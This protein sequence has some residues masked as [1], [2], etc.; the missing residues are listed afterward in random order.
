MVR[1]VTILAYSCQL[2]DQ[3]RFL[4]PEPTPIHEDNITC[5]KWSALVAWFNDCAKHINLLKHFVHEAV[6]K[7]I[8]KLELV[9][10]ADNTSDILTKA[11]SWPLCKLLLGL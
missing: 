7:M 10:S 4:Q 3:H 1:M 11:P 5:I 9:D 6:D 8:F 2:L